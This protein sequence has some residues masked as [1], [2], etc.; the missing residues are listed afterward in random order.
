VNA[1]VFA[2]LALLA[3]FMV[4][5]VGVMMGV[6]VREAFLTGQISPSRRD[7]LYIRVFMI[8]VGVPVLIVIGAGLMI[9]TGVVG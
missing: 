3:A 4:W 9:G 8:T 5:L 1:L 7:T 2:L 6:R